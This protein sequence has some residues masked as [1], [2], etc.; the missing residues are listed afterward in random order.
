MI[1]Y[2]ENMN[3]VKQHHPFL[4]VLQK[5]RPSVRKAIIKHADRSLIHCF[6]L[7]CYNILRG[8]IKLKP[9]DRKQLVRHRIR[10]RK[11]AYTK[12]PNTVKKVLLQ[13]GGG[14]GFLTNLFSR[15]IT[16][17]KSLIGL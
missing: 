16:G 13:R 11:I 7:I 6:R 9:R 4:K 14:N 12:N 8:N 1:V 2:P 3:I 17:V 10:L 15:I 5:A